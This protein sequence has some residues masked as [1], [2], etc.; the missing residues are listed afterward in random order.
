[1]KN[2][3]IVN[4]EANTYIYSDLHMYSAEVLAGN[5]KGSQESQQPHRSWI[6]NSLMERGKVLAPQQSDTSGQSK[7]LGTSKCAITTWFPA[8]KKPVTNITHIRTTLYAGKM[9]DVFVTKLDI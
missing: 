8:G 9:Q 3:C 2:I 4:L 1:M 7:V 5:L 6:P